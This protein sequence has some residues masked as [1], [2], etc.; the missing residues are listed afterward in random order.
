MK[1]KTLHRMTVNADKKCIHCGESIVL[2]NFIAKLDRLKFCKPECGIQHYNNSRRKESTIVC[3]L[4]GSSFLRVQGSAKRCPECIAKL[5]AEVELE[6]SNKSKVLKQH[7]TILTRE[8]KHENIL[9]QFKIRQ[10]NIYA[11]AEKNF[12]EACTMQIRL[13]A[14]IAKYNFERMTVR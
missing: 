12:F 10:G 1:K 7:D 6:K 14:D 2:K 4:C 13:D 8:M 5:K 3:S 9:A 11:M